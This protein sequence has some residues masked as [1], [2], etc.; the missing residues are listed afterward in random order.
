MS[1]KKDL[2]KQKGAALILSLMFLIMFSLLGAALISMAS[3]ETQIA[4][5]YKIN[6]QVLYLTEAGIDQARESLRASP[7][8]L[9]QILTTAGGVDG[10][11]STSTDL[12]TLASLDQAWV[13]NATLTDLTGRSQGQYHVFLRNDAADGP[14]SITDTNDIISLIGIGR[15]RGAIKTVEVDVRRGAIP[16]FPAALTLDGPVGYFNE[17]NSV[18]FDVDGNDSAMPPVSPKSAIGVIDNAGDVTVTTQIQGPPDRSPSYTGA[19]GTPSINDVSGTLA[20]ELVTPAGLESVV[21]DIASYATTTYNPGFSGSVSLG[22]VGTAAN[23][24][25]VVVN[26]DC[27]FGPG[28]GYGILLVRGNLTFNGDFTWHG[29]IYVIGQGHMEWNG[30]AQGEISGA[31]LIAASRGLPRTAANPVGPLLGT[32]GP[33]Y[34]DFN[35]GGGNGIHYHSQDMRNA[36]HGLPFRRISYRI[37]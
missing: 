5:N 21:A 13:N 36:N 31:M 17:S 35:G 14:T 34:A 1:S 15:F 18:L 27:V 24:Q 4:D 20:Q 37:F 22:N 33:V 8:T 12:T 28:T 3:M 16:D 29:V 11:L 2:K 7:N 9:T 25:I 23:P 30:G 32:R 19:G 6:S 26:G 10:V